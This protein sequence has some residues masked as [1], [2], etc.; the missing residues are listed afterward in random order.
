MVKLSIKIIT[1]KVM[2]FL[3]I[4]VWCFKYCDSKKISASINYMD[5]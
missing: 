5:F 2:N 4:E 3:H 1:K